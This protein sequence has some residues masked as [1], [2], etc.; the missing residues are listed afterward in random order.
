MNPLML[1]AMFG[2]KL[3]LQTVTFNANATWLAPSGVNVLASLAG[4]GVN[5]VASTPGTPDTTTPGAKTVHYETILTRK[6]GTSDYVDGG[7]GTW[8]G[9]TQPANTHTTTYIGDSSTVYNYQDKYVT[10]TQDP[11][12]VTPGT[13]GTPGS[14]GADASGFGKTFSGGTPSVPT[15]ATTTYT[16]A[17]VTSGTNYP[18]VVPSGATVQITYYA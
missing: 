15:A 1:L 16:N 3:E 18:V 10:Y 2:R 12:T 11:D 4:R 8:S 9:T 6:D 14:Y 13:P 7:Y 17:A 5:G